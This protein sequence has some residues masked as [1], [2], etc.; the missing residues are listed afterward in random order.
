M[1]LGY[2]AKISPAENAIP[3]AWLPYPTNKWVPLPWVNNSPGNIQNEVSTNRSG[4]YS[5][6][7]KQAQDEYNKLICNKTPKSRRK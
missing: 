5:N 6:G 1:S 4:A 7:I 3:N 2:P